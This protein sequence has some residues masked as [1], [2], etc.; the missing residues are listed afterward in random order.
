MQHG[1]SFRITA[2]WLVVAALCNLIGGTAAAAPQALIGT[3]L[4]PIQDGEALVSNLIGL[5]AGDKEAPRP[6]FSRIVVTEDGPQRLVVTVSYS[7]LPKLLL[8]AEVTGRN[9]RPQSEIEA[10]TVSLTEAAGE[11]TITLMLRSDASQEAPLESA[12]LRVTAVNPARPSDR[13]LSRLFAFSRTKKWTPSSGA[14]PQVQTVSP[15]PIG[16]A[17]ALGDKPNYTAPPRV[18]VPIKPPLPAAAG[19]VRDHRTGAAP[20][21][22]VRDHRTGAAA[23]PPPVASRGGGGVVVSD[24]VAG[25]RRETAKRTRP[26]ADVMAPGTRLLQIEQVKYG[27]KPE[28]AQKGALGPA[29]APIELL[30]G[31]TTEDIGLSPATLLSIATNIYPD[32]NAASG[33]FYYHPRSYHLEWTPEGGHGMRILYGA[34][35][36]AAAAGDVLM[37]ARLQSG[38]DLAEVQLAR[39][40]LDAYQRR[41]PSAITTKGALTLRPLP[42]QKGGVD[43][44]LAAVLGQYSIPNEK[45]AITGLSDVLGEIEVSWITD[46]V[47]KENLQLALVQDI[48]VNGSVVFAATGGELAPQVPIS[49]Q[50][51]DRNSFGRVRW[52]RADGYRNNTPYPVRL[53]YLH[54]LVVDPVKHL[55]IL[56]TWSLGDA[57]VAPG[58]RVDWSGARVPAWIDT[59]AKRLWV[60]YAVVETCDP[61]DRQVLDRITGGVSAI[62]A[63]QITF[64]T[65]T[66][67]ADVGGYELTA[68]VRSKYFDPKDRASVEKTIVLKADNQDFVLKPIFTVDRPDGEPLF[69]YL[70]ELAMPDGTIYKGTRWIPSDGV[71]VLIGRAQLEQSIGKLPGKQHE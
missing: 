27:V 61:C 26:A 6:A 62:T 36:E 29:A 44:S 68:K 46:P 38:L 17:R 34:S 56:Y 14:L 2:G 16:T 32:K 39:D 12:Y 9:R 8:Q 45:V 71:R 63:D 31:L 18:L 35:A 53:R 50:L 66:P 19:T 25:Q 22:A 5:L 37:A 48:G 49:I 41:N 10:Q 52:N 70:L 42:L 58:A 57:T 28:D 15:E 64:H 69:E 51:A 55:P 60:D 11:T 43:V 54:A 40:L 21:P 67:L 3:T 20:A 4:R 13:V 24:T 33:V 30:E 47:T 65:I 59:I 1:R 23:Q 7:G